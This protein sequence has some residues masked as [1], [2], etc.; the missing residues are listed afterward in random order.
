MFEALHV[1]SHCNFDTLKSPFASVTPETLVLDENIGKN[2]AKK[3]AEMYDLGFEGVP[4]LTMDK[5]TEV[6]LAYTKAIPGTAGDR[7]VVED[8]KC[9]GYPYTVSPYIDYVLNSASVPVKDSD[10]Y[11]GIGHYGYLAL[12]Q[13]GEFRLNIDAV[14][15]A[16]FDRGTV[17]VGVSTDL[18]LTEL[19]SKVN[20][21]NQI[22]AFK[23]IK[24][25]EPEASTEA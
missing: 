14:S 23:L 15:A 11:I 22:Q 6:E 19:S 18:S 25:V 16:N 2:L 7:T 12:Q 13:H 3:I 8:G 21:K 17:T 1:Y 5:V 24:L 20:G 4:Y 9:C 10:R